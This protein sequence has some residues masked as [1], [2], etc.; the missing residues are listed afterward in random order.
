M[1][2]LVALLWAAGALS[3]PVGSPTSTQRSYL[4]GTFALSAPA[5][6]AVGPSED[7]DDDAAT[8]APGVLA[9]ASPGCLAFARAS[10]RALPLRGVAD[11]GSLAGCPRGPPSVT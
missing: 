5:S 9:V 11:S 2:V 10:G 4:D 8:A 7:E 6:A 3:W 1:A